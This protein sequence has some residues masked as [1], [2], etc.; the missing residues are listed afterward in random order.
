MATRLGVKV[1]VVSNGS[2]PIRPP[3]NSKREHGSRWG[4]SQMQPTTGFP[5]ASGILM[6]A[7]LRTSRWGSRCLKKGALVISPTWK[8]MDRVNIGNALAGRT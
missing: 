2:R 4:K 7:S 5:S 8:T 1:F 3:G 6:C